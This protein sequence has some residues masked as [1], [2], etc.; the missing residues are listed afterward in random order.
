MSTLPLMEGEQ[1]QGLFPAFHV[2]KDPPI[3]FPFMIS[4]P[5][6]QLQGQSSYG[7]QRLSHQVLAESTTHQQVRGSQF[8]YGCMCNIKGNLAYFF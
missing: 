7:D 5:V 6:D 3:L 8:W 4:T 1:D 2:T